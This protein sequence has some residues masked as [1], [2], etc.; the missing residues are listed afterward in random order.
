[1]FLQNKFCP[2][3]SK[4]LFEPVSRI[5]SGSGSW[6]DQNSNTMGYFLGFFQD[7]FEI[8]KELNLNHHGD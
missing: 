8:L 1:M 3:G 7:L 2:W 4:R 6:L 5:T